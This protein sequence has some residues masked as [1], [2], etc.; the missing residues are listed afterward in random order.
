MGKII[1]EFTDYPMNVAVWESDSADGSKY[2]QF[3]AKKIYKDQDGNYKNTHYL[4]DRDLLV[5]KNL[6]EQAYNWSLERKQSQRI[7]TKDRFET[8]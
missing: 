7:V 6:I 2:I 1:K 5:L 3:E 8:N 4:M